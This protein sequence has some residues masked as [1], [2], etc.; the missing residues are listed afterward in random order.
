M[1]ALLRT[2]L[3]DCNISVRVLN[4]LKKA[5]VETIGDLVSHNKV[6]ILKYRD[7][8]RKALNELDDLVE[9]L[10]LSFGMDVQKYL[11]REA[12]SYTA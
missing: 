1:I 11:M 9:A 2:K 10:N 6:D 3:E 8:G 7:M 12:D 4:V 5:E